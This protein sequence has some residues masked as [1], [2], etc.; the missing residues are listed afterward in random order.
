M[1]V[2]PLNELRPVI[3]EIVADE[4]VL[5]H[6]VELG[7]GGPLKQGGGLASHAGGQ[8]FAGL[9]W[10]THYGLRHYSI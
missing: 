1:G 6:V 4:V 10:G 9:D 3:F 7:L 8:H 2:G 5:G